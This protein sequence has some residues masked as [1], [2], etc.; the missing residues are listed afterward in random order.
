MP[1]SHQRTSSVHYVERD[2][3]TD[4]ALQRKQIFFP[5]R[6][7]DFLALLPRRSLHCLLG[8]PGGLKNHAGLQPVRIRS[9]VQNSPGGGMCPQYIIKTNECHVVSIT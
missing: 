8:R 3:A 1:R 2:D 5:N 7:L 6:I 9:D 4:T